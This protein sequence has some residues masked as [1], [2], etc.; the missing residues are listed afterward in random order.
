MTQRLYT[1]SAETRS[2]LAISKPLGTSQEMGRE[3]ERWKKR[4]KEGRKR[5]REEEEEKEDGRKVEEQVEEEEEG[6]WEEKDK[7][8]SRPRAIFNSGRSNR[9]EGWFETES[10]AGPRSPRHDTAPAYQSTS[11]KVS[12]SPKAQHKA[13]PPAASLINSSVTEHTARPAPQLFTKSERRSEGQLLGENLQPQAAA[14]THRIDTPSTCPGNN[15]SENPN[16]GATKR[17]IGQHILSS[18]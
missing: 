17:A 10:R 2:Q 3:G 8:A 15:F 14:C 6:R 1:S 4:R 13:P 11:Q 9:D 12:P 5:R 16:A 7:R 18:T